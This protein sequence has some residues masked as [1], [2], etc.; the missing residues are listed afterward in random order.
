EQNCPPG[1]EWELIGMNSARGVVVPLDSPYVSAAARAI[2]AGFGRAP[3]FIR[4]G[5]SIPVVLAFREKLGVDTLLLERYAEINNV[6]PRVP[7]SQIV[8]QEE[9]QLTP[10][11]FSRQLQKQGLTKT[12][13][14]ARKHQMLVMQEIFESQTRP[15][16]ASA[17]TD[18]AIE[19]YYTQNRIR[20]KKDDEVSFEHVLFSPHGFLSKVTVSDDE[21]AEYHKIHCNEFQTSK[22][23]SV[24]HVFI[25]PDDP[26]YQKQFTPE[27]PAIRQYYTGN[28]DKFKKSEQVR[29]RHIL[30]KPRNTFEKKLDTFTA[31]L[32][33]FRFVPATE[34]QK[35]EYTFELGISDRKSG[36]NLNFKDIVLVTK[37][38]G[39]YS[40]DKESQDKAG[41]PLE[42]PQ[43]GTPSSGNVYGEVCI[44]LPKDALP[45]KL[46]IRDGQSQHSFDISGAHDQEQAFAA[47]EAEL[48]SIQARIT[49][50]A[51]FAKLA[52]ELSEDEGSKEKGGDLGLFG[53]GQMVKPFEEAAFA[54][55]PGSLAGPVRTQFGWHL[56]KVEEKVAARTLSID[57]ARAE[58]ISAIRQ[59]QSTQKAVSDLE[60]CVELLKQGTRTFA[61]LAEKFST[62]ESK[63][64]GGKL[65]IFW[66]GE[67]TEDYTDADRRILEAEIGRGNRIDPQIEELLFQMKTKDLSS[68]VKTDNGY[69]LFQVDTVLDPAQLSFTPSLKTRIRRLLE[70]KKAKE[71]AMAE[72]KKMA[73]E[74]GLAEVG[75][76]TNETSAANFAE[77]TKKTIGEEPV[78]MGPLP[79]SLA[80]GFSSYGLTGAIGQVSA[81]GRTYLPPIQKA[82]S[83]F[84]NKHR[85]KFTG[86]TVPASGTSPEAGKSLPATIDPKEAILGPIES[87]LGVHF[88]KLTYVGIDMYEPFAEIK[89]DLRAMLTQIPREEEVK[90]QFEKNR[91]RFDK[92]ATRKVR[93]MVI[94]DEASARKAYDELKSGQLFTLVSRSYSLDG[95]SQDARGVVNEIKKGQLPANIDEKVWELKKGEYTEPLQTS[96]GW[97]IT[98]VE[99]IAEATPAKYE[100]VA[101]QIRGSMKNQLRNQLAQRFING[102]RQQARIVRNAEL[103]SEL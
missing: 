43:S 99:E 36:I 1:I 96:Y 55:K 44:Q 20:F 42:F 61:Q 21:V 39:R 101:E 45:A 67:F 79:F 10:P 54:A 78:K 9:A 27:E 58:I 8:K 70:E 16:T 18:A 22:R 81:D 34:G 32:R 19:A 84:V 92:P 95:G 76:N 52:T 73:K 85:Q 53:H 31:N 91:E 51:D 29:A 80:P 88:L 97:V 102:L 38:G 49:D 103:L 6:Q 2:E 86:S 35:S 82:L 94:A 33:D 11:E 13:Y 46:E 98:Q 68:V 65:P 63:K 100:T 48:K 41:S 24:L 62:G 12:E 4:E 93:Q 15:M 66:K 72:A 77:L 83:D 3:V 75:Q 28:L 40:P 7:A 59:E 50:G 56:I 23:L 74:L 47:A 25:N 37:D 57:E 89:E 64:N 87:D 5:G 26:E 69:H 60:L 30:I 17:A 71:L 90:S 14:Q